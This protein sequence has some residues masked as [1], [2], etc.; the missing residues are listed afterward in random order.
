M[1]SDVYGFGVVLL[2]MLT[3]LRS[4]DKQ[5]PHRQHHLVDWM[6]PYLSYRKKLKKVMDIRLEGAYPTNS[7]MQLC[8]VAFNCL[9]PDPKS[10]PSMQ[11]IVHTLEGID[12]A[13]MRD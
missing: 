13:K 3:G 12:S 11:E 8:K 1:K 10:R 7:A 2:E 6:R 4:I 5:R 9:K